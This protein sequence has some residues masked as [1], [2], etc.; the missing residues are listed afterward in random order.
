FSRSTDGALRATRRPTK[1]GSES[2]TD[3]ERLGDS[4]PVRRNLAH[5]PRSDQRRISTRIATVA[6]PLN[7]SLSSYTVA[8]SAYGTSRRYQHV[9]HMSAIVSIADTSPL[10][11]ADGTQ[12]HKRGPPVCTGPDF[13]LGQGFDRRQI[14]RGE[15]PRVQRPSPEV[16]ELL[17]SS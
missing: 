16:G 9:R 13:H 5:C 10:V 8:M 3:G 2:A 12:S 7:I 11:A 4:S 1:C 6:E 15:L 14:F 17:E